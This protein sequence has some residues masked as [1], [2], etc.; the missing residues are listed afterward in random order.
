MSIIYL[1]IGSNKGNRYS[2][3]KEAIA[4]IGNDVGQIILIS[5]IYETKSWGF[6]SDD[7]LNLC[8]KIRSKLEPIDLLNS[9]KN[10]EKILGRKKELNII[11]ARE[12]DIDIIFYSNKVIDQKNLKIP[13]PRLE[14]RNFVLFP[15]NDIAPDHI[16]PI[17]LRSVKQILEKSNDKD[18]PVVS[19]LTLP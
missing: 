17:S 12:I 2:I 15:L 5:K 7:F 19:S 18:I 3:I 4:L 11:M 1:S 16:H 8:V 13:H 9:V 6:E 14:L 10:I